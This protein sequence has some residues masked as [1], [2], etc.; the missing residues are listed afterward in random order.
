MPFERWR[1]GQQIRDRQRIAIPFGTPPGVYTL[2]VGAQR[3]GERLAVTPPAL[4]DGQD[5]LRV[6]TFEVSR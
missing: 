5:R 4:A 1:P 2:T 3:A 6:L